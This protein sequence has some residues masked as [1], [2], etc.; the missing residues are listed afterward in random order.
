MSPMNV[1]R[2]EI[3]HDGKFSVYYFNDAAGATEQE[4]LD[5]VAALSGL[6]GE[7]SIEWFEEVPRDIIPINWMKV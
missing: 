3:H 1:A 7:Y 5:K 6:T 2:I 4:L